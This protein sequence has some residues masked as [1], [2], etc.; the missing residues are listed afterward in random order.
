MKDP[1]RLPTDEDVERFRPIYVVWEVTLACNLKCIHCGSRAGSKRDN[2][3]NTEECISLIQQLHE[4]G[5]REIT[6]IGGEAY[7][8]ADW[9]TLVREIADRGILC[10]MQS[11]GRALTEEKIAAAAAAGLTSAGVSIDG[12]AE[13]HDRLR[14]VPG[15]FLQA[16]KALKLFRKYGLSG[17]V[18]TQI[19]NENIG[20]LRALFETIVEAGATAW[21]VQLTVPMGNAADQ[22]DLI[23]QPHQIVDLMPVLA[24]LYIRGRMSG[25]RVLPGN[26]IGYFGPYESMWRSLNGQKAYYGGC[27]AGRSG[28]G[29]EAD[30][31]IKGCPSLPTKPYTGGNIR[32]Q[33]LSEILSNSEQIAFRRDRKKNVERMWGYC[34][35]CY[36]ND[37]CQAGCTW[38][39]HVTTGVP[40]NN[41]FCHYR[42]LMLKQNGLREILVHQKAPVGAPFD[43]GAFEIEVVAD[44]GEVFSQD[45][46]DLPDYAHVFDEQESGS[47]KVTLC[48]NC[49]EYVRT[50]S[51]ACHRC[52][53]GL[54]IEASVKPEFATSELAGPD[55]VLRPA[56]EVTSS[57]E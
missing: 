2:E 7:L 38:T 54:A 9:L 31:A 42:A 45:I 18:N 33:S 55:R 11:G 8:R 51:R 53:S 44:N 47:V 50:G 4:Q 52:G 36:Y 12:L 21:Q 1:A 37:I 6:L 16:M 28:L 20:Q 25:C 5:T 23:L 10:G 49:R 27:Q 26:N 17:T 3:L 22:P 19:N 32:N 34:K 30:G 24:E 40:G 39:S 14:G 41:P 46:Y 35:G 29:I 48:D 57:G 13:V 15:S 43:Y 56:S